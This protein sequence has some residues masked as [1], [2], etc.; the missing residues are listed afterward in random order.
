MRVVKR[1]KKLV[2]ELKA[3]TLIR[4]SDRRS[5]DRSRRLVH[6]FEKSTDG[7]V[8]FSVDSQTRI[9]KTHIV[10]LA[11]PNFTEE[12][13]LDEIKE[14]IKKEDIKVAC[15][16]EAFLYWGYKYITYRNKAGI[17]PEGRPPVI[18][19]PRQEGMLCK[20]ILAVLRRLGFR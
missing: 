14:I 12:T 5:I 1:N 19:N 16:C 15:S 20:H 7:E 2:L 18:R 9:G 3:S 8:Y 10:I 17:D 4:K 6:R 13:T 11:N